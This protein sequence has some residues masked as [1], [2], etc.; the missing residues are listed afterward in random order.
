MLTKS[1]LYLLLSLLAFILMFIGIVK[2]FYP[3]HLFGM[4]VDV[5]WLPTAVLVFVM[6][7]LNCVEIINNTDD[8]NVLHWIGLLLNVIT[9]F[10]VT[11]HLGVDLMG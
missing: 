6:P 2:S 8:Y 7:L 11:R 9:M 3:V 5:I 10:F 1:K 4:E